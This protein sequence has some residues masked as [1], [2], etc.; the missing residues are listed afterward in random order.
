MHKCKHMNTFFEW[1]TYD[2]YITNKRTLIIIAHEH[3]TTWTY[4]L[5]AFQC[6]GLLDIFS[7][8]LL[9]KKDM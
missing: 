2:D 4:I 3:M 7:Q 8:I 1:L 5:K 9:G 6:S